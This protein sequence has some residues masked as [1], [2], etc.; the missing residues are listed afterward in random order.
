MRLNQT[1]SSL[2]GQ[3]FMFGLDL[4]YVGVASG[5]LKAHSVCRGRET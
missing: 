3:L 2:T 1:K 4:Q 5:L